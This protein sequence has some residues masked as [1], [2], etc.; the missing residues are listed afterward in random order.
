[1]S[2]AVTSKLV[3]V[4]DLMS[5][6]KKLAIASPTAVMKGVKRVALKIERDAKAICTELGAVDTGRLRAS[7]T[8]NWTGSGLPV[9]EVHAPSS[10]KPKGKSG[11]P[12]KP[13]QPSDLMG[14]P[15][16][17][18][19][20]FSAVVGTNVEYAPSI[21]HGHI[22]KGKTFTTMV[23]GRPFLYPA[24]F[25]HENEV[26]PEISSELGKEMAKTFKKK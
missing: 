12:S 22:V 20:V 8:T 23:S 5:N 16:S 18:K 7:I 9:G 19:D 4:E 25:S 11:Q 10:I 21:E 6:I 13:L 26:Q 17:K 2:D 1:M 14:Q 3:G 15:Q 24:Y